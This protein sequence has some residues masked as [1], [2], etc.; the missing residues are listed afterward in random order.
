MEE[1]RPK[2]TAPE[3]SPLV[4]QTDAI[5]ARGD[6]RSSIEASLLATGAAGIWLVVS[7]F[8]LSYEKPAAPLVWGIVVLVLAGLRLI[9]EPRSRLLAGASIA[10]GG[11]IVATAFALDDT[12]GPTVSM[13]LVG[14]AIVVLQVISIA[15]LSERR[16]ISRG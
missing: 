12:A 14:L 9:G 1:N 8:A 16:H 7:A 4:E 10:C 15:A 3:Q 13:A 6:W 2:P 11:L 5:G